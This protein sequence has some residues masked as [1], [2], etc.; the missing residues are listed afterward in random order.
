M[1]QALKF[2]K[3][4]DA[5]GINVDLSL[6]YPWIYI[7]KINGN[8]VTEKYYSDHQYTLCFSTDDRLLGI[9]QLFKLVRKYI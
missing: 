1:K 5:I 4:M 2:K 3:R 6:N 8:T 9:P 7:D